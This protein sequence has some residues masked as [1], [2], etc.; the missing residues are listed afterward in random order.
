MMKSLRSLD[1]QKS[2]FNFYQVNFDDIEFLKEILITAFYD[3]D[4]YIDDDFNDIISG[5]KFKEAALNNLGW[6][7]REWELQGKEIR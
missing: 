6:D 4:I 1:V 5:A 2:E 7:W 3:E